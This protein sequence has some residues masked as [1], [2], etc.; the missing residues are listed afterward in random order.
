MVAQ[1]V[2]VNPSIQEAETKED[3]EF[4]ATLN[5]LVKPCLKTKPNSQPQIQP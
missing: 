2:L 4:Q 1:V 5:Y 3:L